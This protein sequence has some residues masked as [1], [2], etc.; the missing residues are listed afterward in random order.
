[1]AETKIERLTEKFRFLKDEVLAVLV[2]GSHA[3][4]EETPRSDI[5]VCIVAPGKDPKEVLAKVFR[6]VDTRGLDIYCFQELP[7]HIKMDVILHHRP[8]FV[9]DEPSLYEYFY[10]FRKIWADQEHRQSVTK[11]EILSML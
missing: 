10:T 9:R 2:F 5:D 4:S 1:M 3:R 8:L 11:G 7:L 6:N